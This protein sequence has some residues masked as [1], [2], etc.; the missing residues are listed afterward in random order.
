MPAAAA[1][2]CA[3][4]D[5]HRHLRAHAARSH[6]LCRALPSCAITPPSPA[7]SRRRAVIPPLA[8]SFAF[9]TTPRSLARGLPPLRRHCTPSHKDAMR[10]WDTVSHPCD[11]SRPCDTGPRPNGVAPHRRAAAPCCSDTLEA[12]WCPSDNTSRS[13]DA[14]PC[15]AHC[16]AAVTRVAPYDVVL[17]AHPVLFKPCYA[18]PLSYRLVT[19]EAVCMPCPLAPTP[20]LAHAPITCPSRPRTFLPPSALFAPRTPPMP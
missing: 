7:L 17:T 1:P 11:A 12:L 19:R 8:V 6:R 20:I 13:L 18:P 2:C 4:A 16:S 3:P 5:P 15:A 9:A 10:P 14:A